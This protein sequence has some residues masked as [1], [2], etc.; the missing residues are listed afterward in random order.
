METLNSGTATMFVLRNLAK[1]TPYE[2]KIQPFR[3][4]EDGEIIEGI[5]SNTVNAR[6]FQDGELTKLYGL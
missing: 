5:D 1:Y 4:M 2:I 3:K 6:T